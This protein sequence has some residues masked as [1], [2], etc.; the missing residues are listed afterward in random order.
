[1][2]DSDKDGSLRGTARAKA[3]GQ[4]GASGLGRR[5]L[6]VVQK[7]PGQSGGVIPGPGQKMGHW[8]LAGHHADSGFKLSS[9]V[10]SYRKVLSN[11][12]A[13][14]LTNPFW[15]VEGRRTREEAPGRFRRERVVVAWTKLSQ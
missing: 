9:V 1:M 6:Q 11:A 10:R 2:T 13:W 14:G 4:E 3:L 7:G 5:P 15:E 8:H 12:V